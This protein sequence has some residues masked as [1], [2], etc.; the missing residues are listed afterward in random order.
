M[1]IS[2]NVRV[3]RRALS[4]YALLCYARFVKNDFIKALHDL[5]S[6]H[7]LRYVHDMIFATI[8]CRHNLSKAGHLINRS[9]SDNLKEKLIMDIY[10]LLAFGEG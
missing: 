9:N 6:I 3:S 8:R 5:G 4:H 1:R 7:K 10:T 2:S